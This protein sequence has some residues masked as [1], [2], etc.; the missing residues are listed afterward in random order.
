LTLS[1]TGVIGTTE[2]FRLEAERA[3]VLRSSQPITGRGF[4]GI[5]A[6]TSLDDEHIQAYMKQFVATRLH[7]SEFDPDVSE[8]VIIHDASETQRKLSSVATPKYTYA[9]LDDFTD[10]IGRTV[11]GTPQTSRVERKGVLPQ[12]IY[13]D[14]SQ[15]RLASY[16]LKP[17]DLGRVLNARNITQPAGSIDAGRGR[18][19]IDPSG[20][21]ESARAVGDV[22]LRPSPTASPFICAISFKSAAHIKLR[23]N[24]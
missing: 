2:A 6:D 23:Q 14:Y 16:G 5:D 22:L 20:K 7:E 12:A 4:I 21:F 24:T 18:I 15:E 11:L 19:Q 13:L 3:G 9:Q 8:A 1:N 17:S 10:L